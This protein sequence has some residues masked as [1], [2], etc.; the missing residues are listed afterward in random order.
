MI[1]MKR[2]TR[3]SDKRFH[4]ES[5]LSINNADKSIFLITALRIGGAAGLALR[6]EAKIGLN[7]RFQ[8]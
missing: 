4:K 7:V 3:S 1:L 6:L 8:G 5:I 2:G